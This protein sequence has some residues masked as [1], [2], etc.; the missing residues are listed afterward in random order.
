MPYKLADLY[1][2]PSQR[3]RIITEAWAAN[4]VYCPSCL[5]P[6]LAATPVNFKVIDYIC[7]T[8]LSSYQLK[9]TKTGI[10]KTIPDGAYH[11]MINA[12]REDQAPNLLLLHYHFPAWEVRNLV[13]IPGF[14]FSEQAIIP[15]KALSLTARRAGWIGCNI[16]LS[17]IAPETRIPVVL[18]GVVLSHSEVSEKYLKLK[19]LAEVKPLD[20]GW[21]LAVLNVIQ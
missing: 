3:A 18:N 15:R 6:S 13:V 10:G 5:N 16:D 19:S 9:S 14:V 7:N 11:T 12:I 4:E 17:R 21:T 1:Q 2:S 20:R 8:C